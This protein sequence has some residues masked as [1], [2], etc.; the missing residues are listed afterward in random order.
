MTGRRGRWPGRATT[1]A[2]WPLMALQSAVVFGDAALPL[3][4]SWIA[5]DLSRSLT[6]MAALYVV[7]SLVPLAAGLAITPWIS[8]FG[9]H[10]TL[11]L[12]QWGRALML[13]G[14]LVLYGTGWRLGLFVWLFL[15]AGGIGTG[16]VLSEAAVR[17]LIPA[18]GASATAY[19]GRLERVGAMVRLAALPAAGIVLATAGASGLLAILTG[20]SMVGGALTPAAA[21]GAHTPPAARP[22]HPAVGLQLLWRIAPLR[23]L[24]LQ[25]LVGNFGYTLVMGALLFY[26]RTSLHLSAVGVSLTMAALSLGSILGTLALPPLL[27]RLRRGVLY[28]LFLTGGLM[29][30][31]MLQIPRPWAPAAGEA[32]VAAC[33][34]A[35]VVMST[36]LRLQL[37]P[38]GDRTVVLTASRLVSNLMVPAGGA[39]VATL[40]PLVGVPALFLAAAAAK[41]AEIAIAGSRDI[42][43][44]DAGRCCAMGT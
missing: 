22:T 26:L 7:E 33:D 39:I 25:A 36:G 41:A 44:I 9:P 15:A 27:R 1:Q 31:L 24:A 17:A 42:R 30:T 18:L 43:R 3:A 19:A 32:L 4:L 6:L 34:T 28:P 14:V 13:G 38:A 21:P 2:D 11:G 29:G 10:R 5:Y 16:V 35:W 12:S 8:R 23:S 40:G 37:I 20:I